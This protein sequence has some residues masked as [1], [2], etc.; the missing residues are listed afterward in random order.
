[1]AELKL[2]NQEQRAYDYMLTFGGITSLQAYNDLGI[3]QLG[4]RIKGLEAKGIKVYRKRITVYNRFKEKTR[5][6]LYSLT[7]KSENTE[8]EGKE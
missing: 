4:A 2:N 7:D 6:T 1:M 8:K 3:S 5:V